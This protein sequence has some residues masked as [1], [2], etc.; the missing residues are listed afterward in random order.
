VN[1]VIPSPNVWNSPDV[2]ELENLAVDRGGQVEAAMRRVHDW[3]GLDV[4]DVGCGTGFHLPRFA[5]SARSVTGVEPHPPLV[6]RALQRVRGLEGVRVLHGEAGALPLPAA[7]VDVVHARW[8]YFFGPG[9]E[10][11][12]GELDRVVRRGGAAFVI[13]NDATRST[14]G[15]WFSRSLPSY[16]PVAVDRFFA[17]RGWSVERLEVA[18]EFDRREDLEAVVRIEFTPQQAD[19]VLAEHAGTSVD[20]AVVLR[21]REF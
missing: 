5:A 8:A 6:R 11:G 18:W 14:F 12:L 10:P 9:C 15:R 17:R 4:L 1:G 2:Y 3:A 19:E 20:Y 7:S 21:Y 13:D 16:D